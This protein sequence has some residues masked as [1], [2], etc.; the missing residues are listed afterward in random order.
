MLRPR[1]GALARSH[2]NETHKVIDNLWSWTPSSSTNT[3]MMTCLHQVTPK[4]VLPDGSYTHEQCLRCSTKAARTPLHRIRSCPHNGPDNCRL[5]RVLDLV[6]GFSLDEGVLQT[7]GPIPIL[8]GPLPSSIPSLV[9]ANRLSLI[10]AI[11]ADGVS[12][13]TKS[14]IRYPAAPNHRK[15]HTIDALV[16]VGQLAY[17]YT[18][19][20]APAEPPLANPAPAPVLVLAPQLV[21]RAQPGRRWNPYH[22]FTWGALGILLDSCPIHRMCFLHQPPPGGNPASSVTPINTHIL[23]T[24]LPSLPVHWNASSCAPPIMTRTCSPQPSARYAD[25]FFAHTVTSTWTR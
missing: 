13:V 2:P 6:T 14:T 20:L 5:E 3:M 17:L 22:C 9:E 11:K 25:K 19:C 21:P 16:E 10:K 18:T 15:R 7:N 4:V 23:S 1:R 8:M 24:P 12:T